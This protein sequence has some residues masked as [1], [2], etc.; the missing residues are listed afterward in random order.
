MRPDG[1]IDWTLVFA[2]AF[3]ALIAVA[4]MKTAMRAVAYETA[5]ELGEIQ[6]EHM[7][8]AVIRVVLQ[9]QPPVRASED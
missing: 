8:R 9:E 5:L 6:A 7:R 1:E 4:W 2:C 3:L